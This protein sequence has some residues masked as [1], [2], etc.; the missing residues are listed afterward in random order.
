MN[1]MSKQ[2]LIVLITIANDGGE[3]TDQVCTVIS[4]ETKGAEFLE[5]REPYAICIS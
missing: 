3:S 4:S 5:V 2:K 1:K